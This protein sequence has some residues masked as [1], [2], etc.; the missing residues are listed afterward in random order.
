MAAFGQQQSRLAEGQVTQT[1]Y[2][3]IRDVKFSYAI[4]VLTQQ[5]QVCTEHSRGCAAVWRVLSSN[6]QKQAGR[7]SSA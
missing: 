3:Y 2:G 5:L 6:M 4:D 7:P 1:I